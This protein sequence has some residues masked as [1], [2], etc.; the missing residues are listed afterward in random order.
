MR[1]V[2]GEIPCKKLCYAAKPNWLHR[3][4]LRE[5]YISQWVYD[6]GLNLA[7]EIPA[8]VLFG[9]QWRKFPLWMLRCP[10][11]RTLSCRRLH[12][13]RMKK[14]NVLLQ[15]GLFDVLGHP[16]LIMLLWWSKIVRHWPWRQWMYIHRRRVRI[17]W[18]F[19]RASPVVIFRSRTRHG[20]SECS[21]IWLTAEG[22]CPNSI[23]EKSSLAKEMD[24]Q[25]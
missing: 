17:G 6:F 11:W 18:A 19:H 16:I 4:C 23:G 22:Q 12:Y 20:C 9:Y 13:I 25:P 8:V 2:I 3:N 5:S 24:C 21:L 14:D 1:H 10:T 7:G 15:L